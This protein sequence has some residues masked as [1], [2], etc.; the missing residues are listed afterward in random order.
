MQSYLPSTIK[1]FQY[2][3]A[4][5]ERAMRQVVE[6][7]LFYMYNDDSNSIAVLVKHLWG[8]MLSR[9]TDFMTSDGEKEWRQRD[10]EFEND[11]SSVDELWEKWEA[12]WKVVFEA[13]EPLTVDD[14]EKIVYIRNQGHTVVEALNRQLAHYAYHIGQIVYR[15]KMLTSDPWKSL[16]IPKGE[17]K[18]FNAKKFSQDKAKGHFTDEFL[19]KE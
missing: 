15:S 4:L 13:L 2:Y 8:N 19:G 9:F 12:G 14:L 10:T 11:I 1:Q 18:S 7:K 3:K 17:S 5:G 16:T 6:E